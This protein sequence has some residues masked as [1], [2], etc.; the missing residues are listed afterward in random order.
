MKKN[1]KISWFVKNGLLFRQDTLRG[2]D[3]EKANSQLVVPAKFRDMVKK[4]AD[5]SLL[6]GHLRNAAYASKSYFRVLL[7]RNSVRYMT[8]LLFLRHMSAYCTKW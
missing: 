1:G 5:D 3:Q 7:A 2:G 8:F 4:L 6:A